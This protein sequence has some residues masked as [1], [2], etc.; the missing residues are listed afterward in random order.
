LGNFVTAHLNSPRSARIRVIVNELIK[1]SSFPCCAEAIT[2]ETWNYYSHHWRSVIVN[3]ISFRERDA[4]ER[5]TSQ[6]EGE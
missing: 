2:N 1:V 5:R 6:N 3:F 4:F